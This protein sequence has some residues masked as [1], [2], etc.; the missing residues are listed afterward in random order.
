MSLHKSLNSFCS[1]KSLE[2]VFRISYTTQKLNSAETWLPNDSTIR[3]LYVNVFHVWFLF[4]W[5]VWYKNRIFVIIFNF[6]VKSY[7]KRII[8]HLIHSLKSHLISEQQSYSQVPIQSHF[9]TI[10][11]FGRMICKNKNMPTFYKEINHKN[12]FSQTCVGNMYLHLTKT[13]ACG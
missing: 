5:I 2:P 4:L 8:L 6:R 10:F 3:V 11:S 13:L 9:L 12:V 7:F 1:T